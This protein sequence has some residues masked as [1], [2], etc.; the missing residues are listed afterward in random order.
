MWPQG[1]LVALE[2][3]RAAAPRH[4]TVTEAFN[5][6]DPVQENYDGFA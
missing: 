6:V 3:L 4:V 5:F 2:K 1:V